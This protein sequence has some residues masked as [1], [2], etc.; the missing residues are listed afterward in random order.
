MS[1][2]VVVRE[3]R[4][5]KFFLPHSLLLVKV[6][7]LYV[8]IIVQSGLTHANVLLV[9]FVEIL[10]VVVNLRHVHSTERGLPRHLSVSIR[11]NR[12]VLVGILAGIG[13][14]KGL[15]VHISLIQIFL[16]LVFSEKRAD[17]LVF[18]V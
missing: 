17:I 18:L 15:L 13:L 14:Q 2:R 10:E 7:I 12:R 6:A 4:P 16:L 11:G 8:A 3:G 1:R 5:R 9:L